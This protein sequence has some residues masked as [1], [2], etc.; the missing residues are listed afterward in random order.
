MFGS[1]LW[2]QTQENGRIRNYSSFHAANH[3]NLIIKLKLYCNYMGFCKLGQ[4]R[5]K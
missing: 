4:D 1:V 2:K 5:A 3:D